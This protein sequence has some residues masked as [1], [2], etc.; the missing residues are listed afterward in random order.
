MSGPGGAGRR[1][2]VPRREVESSGG[3]WLRGTAGV[4]LFR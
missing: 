4:V 1:N 3:E 2:E